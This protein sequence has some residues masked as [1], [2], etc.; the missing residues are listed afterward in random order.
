MKAYFLEYVKELDLISLIIKKEGR[1]AARS[2]GA[3]LG[4]YSAMHPSVAG[5]VARKDRAGQNG[6]AEGADPARGSQIVDRPV[7]QWQS[8]RLIDRGRV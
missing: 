3:H 5:K 2:S 7:D 6:E 1:P 4:G 8:L